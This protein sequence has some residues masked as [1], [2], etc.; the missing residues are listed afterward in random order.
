VDS[1]EAE[2]LIM[3]GEDGVAEWNR[4]RASAQALPLRLVLAAPDDESPLNLRGVDL[5]GCSLF[6]SDLSNADLTGAYLFR[7]RLGGVS[8]YGANLAGVNLAGADLAGANL[9]RASFENADLREAVLASTRGKAR[10]THARLDRADLANA[11]LNDSDFGA[12][13]LVDALMTGVSLSG[14]HLVGADLQGADLREARLQSRDQWRTRLDRANL[15]GAC[16][17]RADLTGASLVG[18]NLNRTDLE[19]ADLT[20]AVLEEARM[21]GTRL[22]GATLNG[23]AVYGISAWDLS[24]DDRTQQ[25]DLNIAPQ[26]E[27]TITVDDLEVAQFMYLLMNNSRLRQVIDTITSKVVLIL[28]R[29]TEDRKPVLEALR[30]ALRGGEFDFVPIIFDFDKPVS[31]TTGETIATLA[32]MARFVIADLTDAKSVLQELR[33]IVPDS[34]SLPVQP[35]LLDSQDEPG[36]LDTFRRYPW[37]LKPFMYAD[38]DGL[39]ARLGDV[40]GPAVRMSDELRS[41]TAQPS[42]DAIHE[43]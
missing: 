31:R 29:F 2:R 22:H 6:D 4:R 15:A 39:L 7:A 16:M 20:N 23:C 38:A 26:G 36:M 8:L 27:A 1:S 24:L 43:R 19:G 5:G 18:A 12:A 21:L 13:S 11:Q 28:G 33:D 10:F 17:S 25:R 34:P 40:I 32:G 14:A 30:Q 41:V 37:F 3:S 42:A 35:L 9:D